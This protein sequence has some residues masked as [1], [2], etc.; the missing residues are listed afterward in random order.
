MM[1]GETRSKEP[2]KWMR[3]HDQLVD[4]WIVPQYIARNSSTSHS[5]ARI[6]NGTLQSL[7]YRCC[8]YRGAERLLVLQEQKI[9]DRGEFTF[10]R[11]YRT[12]RRAVEYCEGARAHL[13]AKMAHEG[14]AN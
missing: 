7:K 11:P 3:C 12:P 10:A 5:N 4:I 14:Q 2:V 13:F 6:G 8:V 1:Q 9:P